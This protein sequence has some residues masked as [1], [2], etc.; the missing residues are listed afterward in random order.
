MYLGS[1]PTDREPL[2][3]AFISKYSRSGSGLNILFA[4]KVSNSVRRRERVDVFR[5]CLGFRV[6]VLP[7][8]FRRFSTPILW[9]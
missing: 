4:G 7:L 6:R 1:K 5:A 9:I 8:K 2:P 3:S